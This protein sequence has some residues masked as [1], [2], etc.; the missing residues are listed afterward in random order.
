MALEFGI[1]DVD[2]FFLKNFTVPGWK[3]VC[4]QATTPSGRP[5][6][7]LVFG[8]VMGLLQGSIPF[9]PKIPKKWFE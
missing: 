6:D 3:S 7:E 2:F 4:G 8:V 9:S 1:F 5:M